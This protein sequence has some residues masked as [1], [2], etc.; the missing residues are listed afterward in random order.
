MLSHFSCVPVF[1]GEGNGNLLQY[2]CLENSID[3]GAWQATIYGVTKS[4]IHLS[5]FTFFPSIV[6]FGEGNGNPLQCSYL[7]N[8]MKRGAWW[9]TV[10]GLQR[11]GHDEATNTHTHTHTHT[12]IALCD[13]VDCSLPG[14]SAHGIFQARVLEGVAMPSSR[15][16]SQ[17]RDRTQVSHIAGRF[18]TS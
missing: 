8:S 15:G 12:Y 14:F 3:K 6:P 1:V 13:P 9:D 11:V 5:N 2:S 16:S 17:P 4:W 10:Y 7:E 18:F